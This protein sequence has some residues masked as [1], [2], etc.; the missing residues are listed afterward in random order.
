MHALSDFFRE[1]EPVRVPEWSRD[2]VWYQI[3]VERFR[4]GDPG[5]DPPG[6]MSWTGD[7]HT[8]EGP[9]PHQRWYG[10]DLA[11]L[12]EGLDYLADLGVTALYLN[13]I[14]QAGS[15]HKYDA[16]D[17]RHVDDHFGVAGEYAKTA[18]REDLH[19]PATW[20]FNESDRMFLRLIREA[21]DRGIRIIVDVSFNHVSQAHPAFKDV[22]EF[23]RSSEYADWFE[24]VCWDP[25]DFEGWAGHKHMPVLRKGPDGPASARARQ[26]IFDVTARWTA[27]FGDSSQGVDGWRL[28]VANEFPAHFWADWRN[29]VKSLNPDAVIVGEVWDICDE[30]LDGQ[31]FD[32]V[33]NY[34]F[35]ELGVAFFGGGRDAPSIADFDQH[36]RLLRNHYHRSVAEGLWNLYDSHDVDRLVSRLKNPGF[37]YARANKP[38]ANPLYNDGKPTPEDYDRLL[39]SAV[40]Q[41]TALGAPMI[42]YGTEVGMWGGGDPDCRKPMIWRDLLPY[43][44]PDENRIEERVLA[45]YKELIGLRKAHLCLSRGDFLTLHCGAGDDT[46]YAYARAGRGGVAVVALNVGSDPC[47]AK[48]Q[49]PD[50][51]PGWADFSPA[52]G[53][54]A[55]DWPAQGAEARLTLRPLQGAILIAE[56]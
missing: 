55:E 48:F 13:P 52:Y 18:A 41:M 39:L 24:I 42:Y 56:S 27:P 10:G 4:N 44:N 34:P 28:D 50:G 37:P 31:T 29:L 49:L 30:W 53:M 5:N 26:H 7:P 16:I 25:F 46:I 9:P 11:G 22:K 6:V 3:M 40:Y 32:G 8:T 36:T 23:G 43:A 47:E 1:T 15:Y 54:A 12:I 51:F 45:A 2:A 33:M 17:W 14:F 20:L 38:S 21:H 19:D 35:A